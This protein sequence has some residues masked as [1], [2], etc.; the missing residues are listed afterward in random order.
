MQLTISRTELVR[1]IA[2]VSR[3]VENRNIMEILSSLRLTAKDGFLTVTATNHHRRS[4]RGS[5]H[6]FR[7]RRVRRG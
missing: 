4:P 6:Q 5:R 1:V 7:R 3:V 2:A